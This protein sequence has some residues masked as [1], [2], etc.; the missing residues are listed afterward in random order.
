[1]EGE[2]ARGRSGR[3]KPERHIAAHLV[4][5][6]A[7][8]ERVGAGVAVC[9]S[10]AAAGV[11]MRCAPAVCGVHALRACCVCISPVLIRHDSC[12]GVW[13]CAGQRHFMPRE[14]LP[15]PTKSPLSTQQRALTWGTSC[16]GRCWRGEKR[17]THCAADR[18]KA[19]RC[20]A[21]SP[22]RRAAPRSPPAVLNGTSPRDT[23]PTSQYHVVSAS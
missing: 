23:P 13:A 11:C 14:D 21:V 4:A 16:A 22:K 3:R 10:T 5:G 18:L 1:M 6:D 7:T 9:C 20:I 19:R 2:A 12:A 17:P 15:R 8:S